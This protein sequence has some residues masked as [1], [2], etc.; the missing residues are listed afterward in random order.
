MSGWC[1]T[2][3]PCQ[4]GEFCLRELPPL[5]AVPGGLTGMALLVAGG[6]ADLDPDGQPGLG[7]R[8]HVEFAVPVTGVAKSAFRTATHA[9]PV[10]RGASAR[11]LHVTAAGC[12]GPTPPTSSGTWPTGTGCPVPSAAPAPS[13]APARP[14]RR[15]TGQALSITALVTA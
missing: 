12:P 6:Y 13:H 4:P 3:S 2:S 1:L 8:A 11:P 9:V 14:S 5:R 7:A 10:L 15:D